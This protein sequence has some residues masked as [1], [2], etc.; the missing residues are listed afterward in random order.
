MQSIYHRKPIFEFLSLMENEYVMFKRLFETKADVLFSSA[1]ILVRTYQPSSKI[2]NRSNIS[3]QGLDYHL[4]EP[5]SADE[6]IRLDMHTFIVLH[7][8]YFKLNHVVGQSHVSSPTSS[9]L[10]GAED[11][12]LSSDL[13]DR[14]LDANP[15]I[16]EGQEI[17]LNNRDLLRCNVQT[18]LFTIRALPTQV[19]HV[20]SLSKGSKAKQQSQQITMGLLPRF[21]TFERGHMY[22]VETNLNKTGYGIVRQ[23]IPLL[24]LK[25]LDNADNNFTLRLFAEKRQRSIE[26]GMTSVRLCDQVL[27]FDDA[28]QCKQVRQTIENNIETAIM[29]KKHEIKLLVFGDAQVDDPQLHFD[30]SNESVPP[31]EPHPPVREELEQQQLISGGSKYY[32]K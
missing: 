24:Y 15:E 20:Q 27:V 11:R 16:P 2:P 19:V 3:Q 31:S 8:L 26:G 6:E 29:E 32:T 10:N 14:V 13:L 23:A 21:L 1:A 17:V 4:R 18:S 12:F 25:T 9:L 7:L 5:C 30:T 28:L 22:I